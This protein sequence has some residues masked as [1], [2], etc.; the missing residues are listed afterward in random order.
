MTDYPPARRGGDVDDHHGEQVPDPYRWLEDAADPET[1]AWVAAENEVTAAF[2][3][4]VPARAAI[5]ARLTELWDFPRSGVPFE[6]GGRWFQLRNTGLQDQGVLFVT[7]DLADAGRPLLDPNVLATDGT[8]AVTSLA[9][10]EDGSTLAYATSAGGSDWK[11]WHVRDI[12]TGLDLDDLIEWSKY[13]GASWRHDG[14]G[15]YYGTVERPEAGRELSHE[16]RMKRIFFHRV[17]TPQGEDVLVFALPEAP[18]SLPDAIVSDDGRYLVVSVRR[19]LHPETQLHVLDLEDAAAG[20]RP[21]VPG[22]T[23]NMEVV[24]NEGATFYVLTDDGADRRRVVAIELDRPERASWREVVPERAETLCEAHHYGGRLVCH[25]LCDAHSVLR[26]HGFGGEHLH[27]VPLPGLVT[28]G[29]SP[30]DHA[31]IEGRPG[32]DVVH[33]EVVSFTESGSLWSHDLG[34]GETALVRPSLAPLEPGDFVTE[35]VFAPS[36]DGTAVPLF[37]TRRK[38]IAPTGDVPV[39]LHGYGGFDIAITPE[40]S[41]THA[42]WLERG[43]ILA[44]AS[45]RG[46]G[47]YGR[48]WYDG[49]RREAKQNVFDDFAGCARWLAASGWSRPGRIAIRGGSNGGL[50]VGACLTQHPELF[51]AAVSDVGVLDMLRFHKFTI[52]WAWTSDFGDPEVPEEYGWLRR[53]SPLHNVRDGTSYP[54]TMLTTGDHDDRVLPGHSLK[55]AA[56]LQAAQGGDA[57]VLLRV[58]TAAGHGDGKPTTKA[59]AENA[60]VL[61]FLEAALGVSPPEP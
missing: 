26:V 44:V 37:L 40:F 4:R 1:A 10:S 30:V 32:S 15:F 50:L 47:E 52:G 25:Y 6:R 11:T 23:A 20:F 28:L 18:D 38:D 41:V 35:Q 2:L 36:D 12:A 53:Y 60:D 61:A 3:A 58:E 34:S 13:S 45:L 46:G 56:R 21:L 19:G 42:V 14:S 54:A 31:G 51:G 29:G 48:A 57:P 59:I 43:G 9:V 7:D 49:G 27:D 22:F 55:F 17:G 8:V 24:A 5:R 33:F 16:S 39:L